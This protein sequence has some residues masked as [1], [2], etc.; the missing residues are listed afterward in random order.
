[1]GMQV[2]EPLIFFNFAS[3]ASGIFVFWDGGKN[4]VCWN[5]N[6]FQRASSVAD[7]ESRKRWLTVLL[8]KN[9]PRCCFLLTHFIIFFFVEILEDIQ[10]G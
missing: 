7:P 2:P 6:N 8:I 10:R 4:R 1:M 3:N 9:I 5:A